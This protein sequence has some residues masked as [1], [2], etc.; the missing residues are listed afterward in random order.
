MKRSELDAARNLAKS[1]KLPENVR[2]G[3]L[4]SARREMQ[5]SEEQAMPQA[6]PIRMPSRMA[7][8]GGMPPS[9]NVPVIMPESA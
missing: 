2:Q 6:N 9:M 1:V 4:A 8:T 5:D 7:S 3:V